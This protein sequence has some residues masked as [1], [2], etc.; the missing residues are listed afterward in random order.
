MVA[1]TYNNSR[2]SKSKIVVAVTKN[3]KKARLAKHMTQAEV[4]NG[5]GIAPNHYARI[6]RGEAIPSVVTL[7]ALIKSLKTKSSKILP[8]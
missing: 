1:L 5:A 4:A 7:V 8:C 2:M 6:E 3:L